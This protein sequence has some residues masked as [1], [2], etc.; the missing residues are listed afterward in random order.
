MG[1][2]RPIAENR[3]TGLVLVRLCFGHQV[4]GLVAPTAGSPSA[5]PPGC[6]S[7]VALQFP[8]RL[9]TGSALELAPVG[10]PSAS[11]PGC[12][13]PL[14]Q[15]FAVLLRLATGSAPKPA[16]V[17]LMRRCALEAA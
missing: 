10:L 15:Q 1:V 14:A 12:L 17:W 8:V 5:S 2:R 9:A 13:F 16:P 4:A 6:L 11:P 7:A 3:Q